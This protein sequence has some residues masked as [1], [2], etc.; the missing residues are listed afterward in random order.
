[1]IG[2]GAA[3]PYGFNPAPLA[4]VGVIME[5]RRRDFELGLEA[6]QDQF[7]AATP[8]LRSLWRSALAPTAAFCA[9]IGRMADLVIIGRALELEPEDGFSLDPAEFLMRAGRPVLLVPPDIARLSA[10]RIVVAWKGGREAR[11]AVHLALPLLARATDVCVVGVG[12]ETTREELED[13]RDYLHLHKVNARAE[14]AGGPHLAVA[15]TLCDFALEIGSDLIVNG[16]YGHGRLSERVLGGVTR[17][18][19]ASSPVCCLMAH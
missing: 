15:H 11:L 16:A 2:V 17:D 8:R 7:L 12:D 3:N 9:E 13:V 1:L 6:L 19:L 10:S 5:Q 18:L 4:G 14:R